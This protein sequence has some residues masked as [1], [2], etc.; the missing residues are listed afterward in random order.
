M[1][2]IAR[3]Y[4]ATVH[5]F[6]LACESKELELKVPP[7]HFGSTFLEE[8]GEVEI[9]RRYMVSV[10]RFDEV[11][12]DIERPALAKIDVQG[13]EMEVLCGMRNKLSELDAVIVEV[14]TIAT[15]YDGPEVAQVMEFF[16]KHG[17]SLADVMSLSARP[18]DGAL[19]QMDLLFVPNL[20][21]IRVDRRWQN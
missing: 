10:R 4:S 9:S 5:N 19:A 21:P 8:I 7:E 14:S 3:T 2:A 20:S 18:L 15:L 17:W 12:G 6:A 16:T 13:F 1:H 11:I